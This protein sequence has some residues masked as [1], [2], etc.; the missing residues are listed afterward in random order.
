MND[1]KWHTCRMESFANERLINVMG[2]ISPNYRAPDFTPSFQWGLCCS[3]FSFLCSVLQIV[4]VLSF[5]LLSIVLS[6]LL[7]FTASDYLPLESSHFSYVAH[8]NLIFFSEHFHEV[9]TPQDIQT[10]SERGAAR[11]KLLYTD[12]YYCVR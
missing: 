8:L 4:V 2:N 12:E 3:I 6:V 7:L 9:Q 10:L 11:M 5:V 1:K